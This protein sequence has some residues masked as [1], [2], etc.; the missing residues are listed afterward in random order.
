MIDLDL[1]G[2]ADQ[3]KSEKQSGKVRQRRALEAVDDADANKSSKRRAG[4]PLPDQYLGRKVRKRFSQGWFQA[5]PACHIS[6]ACLKHRPYDRNKEQC[7]F[8]EHL[9]N[10]LG[11]EGSAL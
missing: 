7:L 1:Q 4:S 2:G 10:F 9:S 3:A 6:H 5:S 11:I 8:T